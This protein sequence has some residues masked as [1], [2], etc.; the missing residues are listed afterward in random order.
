MAPPLP[1]KRSICRLSSANRGAGARFTHV[2]LYLFFFTRTL[3]FLTYVTFGGAYETLRRFPREMRDETAFH[4]RYCRDSR[5]RARQV[6]RRVRHGSYTR[7]FFS[8]R[9]MVRPS[10]P[11]SRWYRALRHART[12]AYCRL[13]PSRA[14][15]SEDS[16]LSMALFT[17]SAAPS[18]S[19][20]PMPIDPPAIS[21]S[22]T[23]Y[24][25]NDCAILGTWDYLD[26]SS[27]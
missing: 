5:Q 18:R 2:S 21:R 24:C 15:D 14:L 26:W 12:H 11:T 1:D 13:F 20:R 3:L 4:C 6:W 9:V 17:T 7:G 23:A 19:R 8:I 27:Y 25:Y 22:L 10:R 16:R